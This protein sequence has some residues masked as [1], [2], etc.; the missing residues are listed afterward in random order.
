MERGNQYLAQGNLDKASVEFR[1]ALQIMPRSPDALY[2]NGQLAE[3]RGNFRAAVGL[4]QA[5]LDAAPDNV[6]A[7]A[8]LARVLVMGGAPDR[9]LALVEPAL[10]RHPDDPE[11]L[12]ARAAARVQLKNEGGA[13]ADAERA[14]QIAPANEY[15][16]ALLAGIYRRAGDNDRAIALLGRSVAHAPTSIDLRRVLASL[17]LA[18]GRTGEAEAA[19]QE[20]VRRRPSELPPRYQLALFYAQTKNLDAAQ[21]T[22]ED[23]VRALPESDEAKLALVDFIATQRSRAQGEKTLRSFLER[24]PGDSALRLGLGAL[25]Q[26]TGATKEAIDAYGEVAKRDG[27]G[28]KGLIARNRI[29][30]LEVA[31]GHKEAAQKLIAEVL[32]KNPYDNDALLLRGKLELERNDSAAAIGD[33]RAVL[34]DQPEAISIRRILARAYI[35]N[36]QPSLAEETLRAASETAPT[37]TAVR[38]DLAQLLSQTARVD[39]AVALLEET[40]L[41]APSDAQAREALVQ[42][43]LAK[44]DFVAAYSAAADLKKLSADSASAFYLSGLAAQGEQRPDDSVKDFE[45][46]LELQPHAYHVLTALVRLQFARGRTAQAI[47]RV[48]QAARDDAKNPIL[49]NLLA[50][51]YLATKDY[52]RA[53][54]VSNRAKTLAPQWWVPYRTLARVRI[55]QND[56]AGALA[57][58]EAGLKIVPLVPELVIETATLDERQGRIDDAIDH[59]DALYRHSPRL[60]IAANNLAMLLVTYR[61]DQRSLDRARDLTATFASSNNADLLDTQGWVHFKRGDYRDALPVLERAAEREP[62]SR[63]IR[64]H[65]AMAELKD[66]QR[67]RARDNLQAALAGSGN[68]SGS[69]EAR[70]ALGTLL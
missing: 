61:K 2:L 58:C 30:A 63:V 38:I 13:R 14:V 52:V 25:L 22:L 45:H 59:Y 18:A 69:E 11:L 19:L 24:D 66:G 40:V 10:A 5:A 48:Q 42:A 50:E 54:E 28:P 44:Q 39:A 67:E 31:Q 57:I 32:A 60:V 47:E 35:A 6:S 3:R 43:Y 21:R 64:Y 70:A 34:R 37:D 46:A 51:L 9:G 53:A 49:L 17:Y 62:G 16:I 15:A 26:R 65:L 29:G 1:N 68:F 27:T 20:I 4:Y 12:T 41:K 56:N 36:G 8:S 55:A 7:C 23:A 33:L